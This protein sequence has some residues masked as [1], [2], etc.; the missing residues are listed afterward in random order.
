MKNVLQIK[1]VSI[2]A[3]EIHVTELV[4]KMHFAMLEI[5]K[6][7]VHVQLDI[8]DHHFHN[9][10]EF[11]IQFQNLNVHMIVSVQMIKHVTIKD[12]KILASLHQMFVLKMLNVVFHIIDQLVH[13]DLDLPEMHNLHVM[14]LDV[15]QTVNVR[16]LK[17]V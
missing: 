10:Q 9:V 6:Q 7:F 11:M 3:V 4:E 12:V 14:N 15:D 16:Q 8:W 17:L 5:I 13:V 1:L 2:N